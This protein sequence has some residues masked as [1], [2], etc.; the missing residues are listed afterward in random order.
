MVNRKQAQTIGKQ[1]AREEI[2]GRS[3]MWP[4]GHRQGWGRLPRPRAPPLEL[5]TGVRCL[6]VGPAS[7][8]STNQHPGTQH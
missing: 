6:L 4:L 5:T 8:R 7:L 3:G 2:A 1:E